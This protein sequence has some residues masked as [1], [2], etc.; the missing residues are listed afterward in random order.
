MNSRGALEVVG[1]FVCSISEGVG[2]Q[3]IE[4]V[5]A[6]AQRRLNLTLFLKLFIPA[7]FAGLALVV[8]A[9]LAPK[10][11]SLRSWMPGL[12]M[13]AWYAGSL[14]VGLLLGVAL[15]GFQLWRR[16][17]TRLEA[18]VEV[19]QRDSLRERL[20][21]AL[22]LDA[23]S[24]DSDA[25][26][27][28]L[29]DAAE[30]AA[31]IDVRDQFP[32]SL[33]RR[34]AWL[35]LPIAAIAGLALIPDATPPQPV[36]V[37]PVVNE[38]KPI[39]VAVEV[40]KKSLEEKAKQLEEQ[41][42]KDAAADLETL[43][44]KLDAVPAGAAELKKEA[45]VKINDVREQLEQKRSELGDVDA[46]KENLAKLKQAGE[47]AMEKLTQALADSDFE[48]ARELVKELARKIKA[49]ELSEQERQRLGEDL[50]K[51]AEAADKLVKEHE[52]AK[53]DLEAQMRQA[54]AEGNLQKAADLQRKLEQ[55]E[56]VE[57]QMQQLRKAAENL[58]RAGEA[59][60]P[61]QK[62]P[63][64]SK[65]KPSDQSKSGGQQQ[66][67]KASP[68]PGQSE[69]SSEQKSGSNQG[70]E[71]L[72]QAQQALEDLAEQM[73]Q[74]ENDQEMGEQLQELEQELQD[75]KDGINGC[76]NPGDN[77]SRKRSQRDFVQGEGNGHGKREVE[78]NETG[79]YRSKVKGR[80]QKGETVTTGDADGPNLP[81]SS[82][83]EARELIKSELNRQT[84]PLE[85][86]Q[87]P[88]AQREQAKEYFQRLRGG[89]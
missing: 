56:A 59:V 26:R 74:M 39:E 20:S 52:Q 84:D 50:K 75:C 48:Q 43:A 87:L 49:G 69:Q 55:R 24:A 36:V 57:R 66:A 65:Q 18:S 68:G 19:D 63:G 72:Q 7:L 13:P 5:V 30:R 83:A 6:A 28:L 17:P 29:A 16:R 60:Q 82:A 21:S 78:E 77:P 8:A 22:A 34:A 88:R 42:L 23:K 3:E 11:W 27:A 4:Q 14:L 2:M 89:K 15:A 61:G 47:G 37:T 1:M 44:R 85:D 70:E 71:N 54:Q 81:G 64:E 62:Q 80:I 25:G 10:F 53:R 40:A 32:L 38:Q 12:E 86:Q 46:L 35:L 9:W 79:D 76:K 67:P 33:E 31:R 73:E 45:L 58:Q 51:L 41:G